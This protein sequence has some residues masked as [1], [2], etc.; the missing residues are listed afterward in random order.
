M[1]K[2]S[3]MDENLASA[4]KTCIILDILGYFHYYETLFGIPNYLESLTKIPKFEVV[5]FCG[6]LLVCN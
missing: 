3:V 4:R 6:K 1:I 2:G 5:L